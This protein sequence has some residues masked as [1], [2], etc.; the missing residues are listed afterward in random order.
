[1]NE[2]RNLK[3]VAVH[4][5]Q[6]H[7][8]RENDDWWGKGFTEWRNV[9][10]S[11]PL[12]RGHYQPHLPGELGFYDLRLPEAR[13]AQA[14][15][16][17]AYGIDGFCYYHYWFHGRR[18]LERPVNEILHSGKPDFPFCLFWANESWEGRWHGVMSGRRTLV[19]Q[20]Y[21]PED[22]LN[23]IRW[24]AAAMADPRYIKVSGRP[25][26]LIYR[27]MDLLDPERTIETWKSE[28][29][30]LGLKEPYLIASDSHACG[31]DLTAFGYDAVVQFLPQLGV[32]DYFHACTF[33]R[34][35]KR[36]LRN[37]RHGAFSFSVHVYEYEDAL[38][39]MVREV[40]WKAH[41]M[42]FPGW[43][44]SPRAGKKGIV[45]VGNSPNKFYRAVLEMSKWTLANLEDD[46]RILF[47]NA[48][49]EWAEGNHLEPDLK[50]GVGYLDAVR[51]AKIDA[52]CPAL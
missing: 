22:D 35:L 8:I 30:R 9:T 23:H 44:N 19:K 29:L 43:D 37:L 14:E 4:L 24:L 10:K 42:I 33:R 41:K 28:A 2:E 46:R 6:F 36:V 27:P 5:P 21:S 31:R 50:F 32:L 13:E 16:A 34:L 12:F 3:Y 47:L 51:K 11:R 48:W 39:R 38:R 7:P 52:Q 49:N 40:P 1:M 26:F 17:R 20:D 18:L 15:L 25:V 45:L